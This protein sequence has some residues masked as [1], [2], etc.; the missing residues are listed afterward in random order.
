MSYI[1]SLDQGTT[2]SRAIVFDKSGSIQ[3]V[4][5][6]EFEQI[7]PQPGWVEHNAQEIWQTQLRVMAD[8]ITDAR[9]A[10][11]EIN[12]I[13]IATSVRQRLFGTAKPG[14]RFTMR[15]YGKIDGRPLAATN[16]KQ[17]ATQ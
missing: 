9:L 1:L 6:Q 7:F 12:A 14:S 11:G 5:Q 15:S 8:V 4:A 13:G 3:A 17:R 10:Q 16:S 2:S